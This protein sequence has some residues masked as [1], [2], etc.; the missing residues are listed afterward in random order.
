M[1]QEIL[2]SLEEWCQKLNKEG[3]GSVNLRWKKLSS[4]LGKRVK[5]SDSAGEV[6]G[7]AI[8]LDKDGGLMIRRDS[9]VVV[10]RLTGDVVQVK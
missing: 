9:G 7:Q 1:L 8:D 4:T 10:K 3:L 6:E 5:I 2:R